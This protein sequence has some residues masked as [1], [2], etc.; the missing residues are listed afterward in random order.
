MTDLAA[1]IAAHPVAAAMRR[2]CADQA[3]MRTTAGDEA[4]AALIAALDADDQERADAEQVRA[5]LD[6]EQAMY[7]S[8][9]ET[10]RQE[11]ESLAAASRLYRDLRDEARADTATLAAELESVEATNATLG[12][13]ALRLRAAVEKAV[14]DLSATMEPAYTI[15]AADKV[16]GD[17]RQ[18]LED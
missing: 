10:A 8:Y 16:L 14:A 17:L 7:S 9:R 18:A 15:F 12:A 6:N 1:R 13:T 4:E 11:I 3:P 2:L 5:A